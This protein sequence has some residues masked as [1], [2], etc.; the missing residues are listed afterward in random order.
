M[1]K[2]ASLWPFN[3]W[4]KNYRSTLLLAARRGNRCKQSCL[5]LL[6]PLLLLLLLVRSNYHNIATMSE[7]LI[8]TTPM[9]SDDQCIFWRNMA[10]KSRLKACKDNHL[11]SIKEHKDNHHKL[12]VPHTRFPQQISHNHS[13][14]IGSW[15][16]CKKCDRGHSSSSRTSPSIWFGWPGN[17]AD[18]T[19]P[20][21]KLYETKVSV[22]QLLS[23]VTKAMLGQN[24]KDW[25]RHSLSSLSLC[26]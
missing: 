3:P 7:H 25:G 8:I 11:N 10:T 6:L 9:C 1:N 5:F 21:W 14:A 15:S 2:I 4:P 26:P 13:W 18:A 23:L 22:S 24:E 20:Q 16:R 12:Q 17:L 19:S